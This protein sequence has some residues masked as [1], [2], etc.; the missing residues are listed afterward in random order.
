MLC[1]LA[2]LHIC[3][4]A[5]KL[6][7]ALIYFLICILANLLTCLLLTCLLTILLTIL[8]LACLL[9]CL[10]NYL[11]TY[12]LAYLLSCLL[13]YLLTC[14]DTFILPISTTCLGV[15]WVSGWMGGLVL[16]AGESQIKTKLSPQLGLA[17]LE[18]G[19]SLAKFFKIFCPFK[20]FCQLG[21]Q[22]TSIFVGL[23]LFIAK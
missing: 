3:F 2:C 5:W 12:L 14:L 22:D 15:W 6:T 19:L 18:L 17:K 8:L 13:A 1:L 10:L 9:A 11:L 16:G 21:Y 23:K 20:Y 4:L 7:C